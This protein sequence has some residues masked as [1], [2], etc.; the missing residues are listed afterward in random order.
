[1]M[2]L[3]PIKRM[4]LAGT[5]IL[6]PMNAAG[7]AGD[8]VR[9]LTDGSAH[10]DLATPSSDQV[11][12]DKPAADANVAADPQAGAAA[13]PD[14]AKGPDAVDLAGLYY[15][16]SLK[17]TDRVDAEARR[18]AFKFPGFVMPKDIYD[19]EINRELDETALWDL[20]DDNDFAG[21]DKEVAARQK[22]IADWQPSEEFAAKLK[23]KKLR[24]GF[25]AAAKSKQ[26]PSVIALGTAIDP[27]SETEVDLLWTLIDAYVATGDTNAAAAI[28]RSILFRTAA[29]FPKPVLIATVQKATRDF[30]PDDIR[31]VMAKFAADPEVVAGLA[32]VY[33]DLN[34]R[35]VA[36]FNGD[37][38]S[39]E[40]LQAEKISTLVAA[41]AKGKLT[42]DYSLLGWYYLKIE[43][44]VDAGVWF[45]K[46]L[47]VEASAEHAKGLYLA[48]VKQDRQDE[49]YD[50]AL[51]YKKD[52]ADDPVFLMNALSERFARPETGAITVD[53]VTAYSGTILATSNPDHSEIL[54][55]YAYKSNQLEAAKA[56]FGKA[57]QWKPAEA[58]VKGLAL[59]LAKLGE[60]E[61]L[62]ALYRK[63]NAEFPGIWDDVKLS[64]NGVPAV[65]KPVKPSFLDGID[66]EATSSLP[67]KKPEVK[68]AKTS[69]T[70]SAPTGSGYLADFNAK[71]F[72]SCIAA[73]IGM[74]SHGKLSAQQQLIKGWCYLGL[75]RLAEA[76]NSFA[77]ALGAGG[78]TRQD[79]AYG[80]A[81]TFLRAKLTDDAQS[82]LSVYPLSTA[83]DREIRAEI[84]WQRA[85]SAFDRKQYQA[86]L[87]ALNARIALVAEPVNLSQLR[88]WS[89]FKLGH[90]AQARAVFERLNMHLDDPAIR[91]GVFATDS[92]L[93]N[94]AN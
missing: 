21:I 62:I 8:P 25:E 86:T 61:Q 27:A 49:A 57:V 14:A 54:A 7:Q 51:K 93:A 41:A 34:R 45:R 28:Y 2:V 10:S 55:W 73:L 74:E 69:R 67:E 6:M 64:K 92:D 52:L 24:F 31:A 48:L 90:I 94:S 78:T 60:R 3:S 46:A 43:K 58:R 30:S 11:L 17:Q 15:Y 81:L 23:R 82:I 65:V 71:R 89:H 19:P 26:W 85:R 5:V 16:A 38:N 87:E 37:E 53:A 59:S 4:L 76:R 80:T 84:Y 75:N 72:S 42:S 36:D 77:G 39:T 29:A 44:P 18:L 35:E 47:D 1:M 56:W 79:A 22:Q 66:D 40:P 68:L 63:F 33:L 88:G 13:V 50:L 20:Y 32:P 12:T 70:V 9:L 83:H 91:R